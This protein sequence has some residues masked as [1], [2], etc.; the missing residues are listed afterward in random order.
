MSEENITIKKN[1]K[2]LPPRISTYALKVEE[3]TAQFEKKLEQLNKSQN[4]KNKLR[5]LKISEII[6]PKFHDRTSPSKASIHEL[7][8]NI[9]EVGLQQPIIV[10]KNE[11][12]SLERIIGYRRIEAM[13]LLEEIEIPA[14]VLE[15]I[16]DADAMLMMVSEN[17]QRENLN[18]YDET[19][20]LLEYLGVSLNKTIPEVKSFLFKIKNFYGSKIKDLTDDEKEM[21]DFV[22]SILQRTGKFTIQT[23]VNRL[24]V[25]NLNEII[26][27]AMRENKIAYS[28]AIELQKLNDTSKIEDLINEIVENGMTTQN[29]I[30]RVG[31]MNGGEGRSRVSPFSALKKSLKDV[32]FNKL[33]KEKREEVEQL[34]EKI[35][36]ILKS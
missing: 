31:Q 34:I 27:E 35:Q 16:T 33:A 9:K 24:R 6:S 7:A 10:R 15:N 36:N 26:I 13:K 12:G 5:N 2:I 23:F 20:A 3:K 32:K 1:K 25:L 30:H 8:K 17:L 19:V 22:N 21:H 4:E 29:I 18:V 14:I 28:I 11:D